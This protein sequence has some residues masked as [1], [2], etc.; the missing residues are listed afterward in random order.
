MRRGDIVLKGGLS[1][2]TKVFKGHVWGKLIVSRKYGFLKEGNKFPAPVLRI[3]R[4]RAKQMFNF[5]Q[6]LSKEVDWQGTE[7]SVDKEDK[8]LEFYTIV[9]FHY[10]SKWKTSR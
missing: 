9:G 1:R 10:F 8:E 3:I 7:I 6:T 4:L 5:K 2:P